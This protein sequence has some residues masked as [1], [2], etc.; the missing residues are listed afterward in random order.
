LASSSPIAA[1]ATRLGLLRDAV[2][3]DVYRMHLRNPLGKGR[4]LMDAGNGRHYG[5]VVGQG[6]VVE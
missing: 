3:D 4:E 2:G 1:E 6:G 5:D